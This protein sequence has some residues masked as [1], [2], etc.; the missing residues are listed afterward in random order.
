MSNASFEL[1]T[2]VARIKGQET[3]VIVLHKLGTKGILPLSP[4]HI[5]CICDPKATEEDRYDDTVALAVTFEVNAVHGELWLVGW[6]AILD[7]KLA[8]EFGMEQVGLDSMV[9]AFVADNPQFQRTL[10]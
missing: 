2:G 3:K 7:R 10:H 1:Y 6:D 4:E 8:V 5:G 9:A